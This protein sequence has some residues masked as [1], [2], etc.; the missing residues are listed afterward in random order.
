[1]FA[2]M[3]RCLQLVGAREVRTRRHYDFVLRLRDDTLVFGP[4]LFDPGAYSGYFVDLPGSV[5]GWQGL[6]DHNFVVDRAH[7]EPF[8]RYLLED[9]Y[10]ENPVSGTGRPLQLGGPGRNTEGMLAAAA[11]KYRVPTKFVSLC[12]MPVAPIRQLRGGAWEIDATYAEL[13]DK[14]IA[15]KPALYKNCFL[16][17]GL[18]RTAPLRPPDLPPG[19]GD[20]CAAG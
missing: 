4:W 12:D 20:V 3:R 19:G 7:A 1:M 15:A 10:L 9:Y 14:E 18:R 17:D 5:G 13:Y 8:F 11:Q 6:N 2:Q 16:R